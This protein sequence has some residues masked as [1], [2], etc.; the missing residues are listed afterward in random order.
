MFTSIFT[1]PGFS[2][3]DTEVASSLIT[4]VIIAYHCRISTAAT[5]MPVGLPARRRA[6]RRRPGWGA[7]PPG[8]KL[9]GTGD[10]FQGKGGGEEAARWQ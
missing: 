3:A 1:A 8:E 10:F 6:A 4:I 7:W 9:S 5:T 2:A